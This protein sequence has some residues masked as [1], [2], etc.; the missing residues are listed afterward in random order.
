MSMAP[1]L[2]PLTDQDMACRNIADRIFDL[3][4]DI[5]LTLFHP[6]IQI[7]EFAEFRQEEKETPLDYCSLRTEQGDT[8]NGQCQDARG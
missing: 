5:D 7:S 8:V 2:A 4:Q 1:L 6:N 3:Q